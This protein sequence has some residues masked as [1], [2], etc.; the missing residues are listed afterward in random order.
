TLRQPALDAGLF[1]LRTWFIEALAREALGEVFLKFGR[2][3]ALGIVTWHIL[4]EVMRVFIILAVVQVLHQ[5]SGSVA[6]PQR[7]RIIGTIHDLC[8]DLAISVVDGIALG[9]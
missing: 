9:C 8:A 4:V 3:R 2:G 6:N 7:H 5:L 1:S